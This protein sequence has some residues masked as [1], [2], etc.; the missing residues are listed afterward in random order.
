[1]IRKLKLR[2]VPVVLDTFVLFHQCLQLYEEEM[3]VVMEISKVRKDLPEGV[4]NCPEITLR[5]KGVF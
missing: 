5:F 1:M 3:S 4:W 2:L